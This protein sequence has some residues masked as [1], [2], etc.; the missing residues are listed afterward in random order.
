[1]GENLYTTYW[2]SILPTIIQQFQ[3]GQQLIQISVKELS[4][5]GNRQ[6]YYVNFRIVNGLLEK[7]EAVF[8]QGRDLYTVLVDNDFFKERLS[9]KTIQITISK[10][11]LLK[12]EILD[13]E[14]PNFFTEEDFEELNK[15]ARQLKDAGNDEHQR[16]YDY[17]K[18]AYTK[19][20]YWAT[21]VQ[22]KVFPNGYVHIVRKPTNQANRFE[23]YHWAKI[24]PDK[25]ALNYSI[26][27]YTVGFSVD[28]EFVVKIDTVGLAESENRRK[29]YLQ[30]RGD[31]RN[32]KIIRILSK[33]QVL[34]KGWKY[35]IDLSA[36][37]IN[38]FQSDYNSLLNLFKSLQGNDSSGRK[39]K[40][41][42]MPPNVIFYGPPGT[43]KTHKLQSL[44][45]EFTISKAVQTKDEFLREKIRE[46][47]WWQVIT[48][49][50]MQ[51]KQA[52]VPE[53]EKHQFIQIKVS[54]SNTV[55]LKQI[56]WGQLQYHADPECKYVKFARRSEPYLFSKNEKSTWSIIEDRVKTEAPEIIDFM[57]AVNSYK[58]IAKSIQKNYQMITFHQNF[59]YEDFIEGIKPLISEETAD[60]LQYEIKRGIFYNACNEAAKLA[61]YNSLKDC[62]T[63]DT[64]DRKKKISEAPLYALFIDEINR[65][66]VSSVLGEL[67]TLLEDDKRLGKENEVVDVV[68]PYSK[69][70]FGIPANLCIIGTM[71]T[72]DRSVE[73]LDTAL[74]RRFIFEPMLPEARVLNSYFLLKQLWLR[75]KHTYTDDEEWLVAEE[76]FMELFGM[77]FADKAG[78]EG[79]KPYLDENRD[80]VLS[81]LDGDSYRKV[82][83]FNN[84]LNLEKLLSVINERLEA[85]LDKDHTIGHAWLMNVHSVEELKAVFR[86]KIL[87]LLQEFFY[88]DYAKIGLVLGKKFVEQKQI[89]QV[90]A[91]FDDELAAEYAE[92]KI[93]SV[94]DMEQLTIEDFKSIYE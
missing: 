40:E 16:A 67:I 53:L 76:K 87:P 3:S 52:T 26:L 78:Y 6:L 62:I 89:K 30:Y 17:L 14:A 39:I 66:N 84:G 36:N 68:L 5:Y 86:T 59:S 2:H 15:V 58:P 28:N 42:I 25:S 54:Q 70:G 55:S 9:D 77:E 90:F 18:A 27:A 43:G 33:D 93:Y 32:S 69:T 85:L 21:E 8:P 29:E 50:M 71:N 41:T 65:A 83:R 35:L 22:K 37:I 49:A 10:D 45:R 92:R 23:S 88:N 44:F 4:N 57:K 73:A 34:D 81:K 64:L 91:R 82:V 19:T 61:G 51:L 94:K 46:L 75:Y 38:S 13:R 72:A 11:L 74:R 47:T 20:A 48:A 63:D 56:L 7:Q 12:I 60:D 79:L 1:M 24:Y 80:E 31:F